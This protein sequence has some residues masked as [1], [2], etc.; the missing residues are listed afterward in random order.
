MSIPIVSVLMPVYNGEKFLREAIESILNQSVTNFEFLIINDGSTDKSEEIILSY[1]DP[2]IR[3]IK[4]DINLK[5]IKTLNK[6]IQLSNGKYI[7]RMDADDVS[8]P[9]RVQKQV[10]F[11]GANPNIGICGSWFEA[12]GKVEDKIVQYRETHDEIMTRM[13]YQCHFCHPSIVFR[14]EIFDD[15]EMYFDE[16]FPHAE[17]YDFYIKVSKKWKFHNL[18]EVL[19]KYRIHD[20]SVSNKFKS[21]QIENSLK[22]KDRFFAELNTQISNEELQA[23][24]ALNYQDY[25]KVK[26][27]SEK[28]QFLLESLWIGNKAKK[29]INENYFENYLQDLWFNYCYQKSNYKTYIKSNELSSSNKSKEV[30]KIKWKIKSILNN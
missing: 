19:L 8:H 4:N 26:L 17:D 14:R 7:V 9:G 21:I 24:E 3:Y 29:I 22:I 6:G 27:D 5:L 15:P 11:M 16:K 20:E 2:R 25:S 1:S 23:F 18:Q 28:L 13:L 30:S 10:N 12:F